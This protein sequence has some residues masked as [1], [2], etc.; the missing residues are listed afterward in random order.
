M[1]NLDAPKPLTVEQLQQLQKLE[2]SDTEIFVRHELG[3][4]QKGKI[5][6][7]N[8]DEQTVK[9]AVYDDRNPSKPYLKIVDGTELLMWQEEGKAEEN[10]IDDL[11]IAIAGHLAKEISKDVK[12]NLPN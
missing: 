8:T 11:D 9:V 6:E 10:A 3:R 1:S 2:N 5:L 7:I 12:K 4:F